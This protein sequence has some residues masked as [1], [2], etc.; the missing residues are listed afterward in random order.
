MTARESENE[1]TTITGGT[2]VAPVETGHLGGTK[3]PEVA[4]IPV[5]LHREEAHTDI[6]TEG[7]LGI[8]ISV[9]KP[10]FLPFLGTEIA[11]AASRPTPRLLTA[12]GVAETVAV[13]IAAS[14]AAVAEETT[15]RSEIIF[16]MTWP[17]TPISRREI[18]TGLIR[19]RAQ[20]ARATSSGTASN[21]SRDSKSLP[22]WTCVRSK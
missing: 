1:T 5:I 17:L 2:N 12:T 4:A 8:E 6:Q 19:S 3:S 21:G 14:V 7:K 22:S 9:Y 16:E 20:M 18:R 13:T 15:V 10:V 11:R